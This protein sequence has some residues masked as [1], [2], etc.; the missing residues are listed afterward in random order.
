MKAHESPPSMIGPMGVLVGL[1]FLDWPGSVLL[2][3]HA[4]PRNRCL[5]A[6]PQ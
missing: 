2:A 5:G 1:L 3:P 6:E 4:G